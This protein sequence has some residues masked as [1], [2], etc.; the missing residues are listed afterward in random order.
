MSKS[1]LLGTFVL[2]G[3]LTACGAPTTQA[4]T[5]TGMAHTATGG[6]RKVNINTAVLTQLDRFEGELGIPAL[7]NQIQ[8]ARPYASPEEL[9]SKKVL[10]AEQ[11]ERIKDQV[12]VEEVELTG[13]AKDV[14]Y[15][16]KLGLMRGHLIVAEELLKRREPAAAAP[17]FGHPVEEIY[18]DIEP[19][20]A[21]RQVKEFKT[22]LLQL[23]DLVKFSPNSPELS[24]NLSAARQGLDAASVV[25][26]ERNATPV[27]L[28]VMSGLLEAAAAEYGAAIAD[29]KIAARIEYEDSRGFVLY[30]DQ[31]FTALTPEL[32]QAD[33]Q[34]VQQVAAGLA[35][36]KTAWPTIDAPATPVLTAAE[37]RSSVQAIGAATQ[38]V[39]FL[40]PAQP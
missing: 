10:S 2:I 22:P 4:P 13:Q 33:P 17:H 40:P 14:D 39:A 32:K 12:T 37:V 31:L 7:S 8:A 20:L 27:V 6:G 28:Q 11:Y 16:I 38:K 19:Q 3:L 9:V 34:A 5:T 1:T 35:R 15:L 23:Q 36:L 25:V 30:A 29:D 24:T 21:E 26:S 18:L